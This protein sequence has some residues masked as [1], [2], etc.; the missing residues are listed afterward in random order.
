M[1]QVE[2]IKDGKGLDGEI[3]L[4]EFYSDNN[5][6][7]AKVYHRPFGGYKAKLLKENKLVRT[8]YANNE[9]DAECFAEDWVH[10]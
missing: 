1:T 5:M 4:S 6:K 2:D 8:L 9:I 3:L 10:E 7:S